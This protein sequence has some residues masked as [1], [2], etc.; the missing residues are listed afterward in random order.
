MAM[1]AGSWDA[2]ATEVITHRFTI[3]VG[4]G[5]VLPVVVA[6]VIRRDVGYTEVVAVA[7][8]VANYESARVE[9]DTRG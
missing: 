3:H 5:Q 7:V 2:V 6:T 1:R 4:S 9:I 8:A